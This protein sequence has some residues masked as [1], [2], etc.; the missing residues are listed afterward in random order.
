[1][2]KFGWY[3]ETRF[4]SHEW[5][6]ITLI[7]ESTSW[8]ENVLL[9]VFHRKIKGGIRNGFYFSLFSNCNRPLNYRNGLKHGAAYD[10]VVQKGVENEKQAI[11]VLNFV[12][13]FLFYN[14]QIIY[15]NYP[16]RLLIPVFSTLALRK[17]PKSTRKKQLLL[18][19]SRREWSLKLFIKTQQ[20]NFHI[21]SRSFHFPSDF[22]P[23]T[24]S[25]I[26]HLF[27]I[28]ALFHFLY[29]AKCHFLL[30]LSKR[31]DR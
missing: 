23:L 7:H 5:T 24:F 21:L 30:H 26:P 28:S 25:P 20:K 17:M 18:R 19:T 16:F 27:P 29:L 10:L 6:K 22:N 3:L 12:F 2:W 15:E 31:V 11:D 1:M 13:I 8:S 14:K 9:I 4:M